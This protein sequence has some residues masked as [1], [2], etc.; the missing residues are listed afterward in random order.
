MKKTALSILFCLVGYLGLMAQ[1]DYENP[2]TYKIGG[3][4]VEGCQYTS[5]NSVIIHSGLGLGQEITLPGSE[6]SKAMK[7]LWDQKVFS[8]VAISA[9]KVMLQ[10]VRPT[11]S[12]VK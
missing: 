6:V 7:S 9:E 2:K 1:V 12:R 4:D 8:E 3:L 11:T 5:K 10:K